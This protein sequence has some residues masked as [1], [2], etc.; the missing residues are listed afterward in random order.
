MNDDFQRVMRDALAAIERAEQALR[1]NR[2]VWEQ[3]P[4]EQ[5]DVRFFL[6]RAP[7][8]FLA[9]SVAGTD[10]GHCDGALSDAGGGAARLV[11][12]PP[13]K[14]KLFFDAAVAFTAKSSPG[15]T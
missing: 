1:E 8:V 13:D 2:W 10:E 11:R 4:S 7:N 6:G 3:G 14:A 5:K 15:Q 12:L 9:L